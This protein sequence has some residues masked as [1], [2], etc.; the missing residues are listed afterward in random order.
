MNERRKRRRNIIN[1]Q[2]TVTVVWFSG[3]I[4]SH[5]RCNFW[6]ALLLYYISPFHNETC[7]KTKPAGRQQPNINQCGKKNKKEQEK[8]SPYTVGK[9]TKKRQAAK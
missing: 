4:S 6:L 7:F 1:Q 9:Q 8:S 3:S 5:V 2:V